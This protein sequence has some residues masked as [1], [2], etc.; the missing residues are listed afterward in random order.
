MFRKVL[1]FLA[2]YQA[3]ALVASL[4]LLTA[5][6]RAASDDRQVNTG[7]VGAA[8]VVLELEGSDE[9]VMG[10]Y[11][12]RKYRL[13]IG[14]GGRWSGDRLILESRSS[15]DR[16]VLRREGAQLAGAL[17][18][19][20]G[21]TLPVRLA[22][23]PLAAGL[24]AEMGDLAPYER[25]QLAELSLVPG[26]IRHDGERTLRDW[27]EPVS[28]ITL[29]RIES[30]YP[31]PVL[32]RINAALARQQWERVSQWFGCEGFD[33]QSGMD[34]SE[35][36]SPY[37]SDDF[38]S[39][40]WFSS[41][42]CA[43]TAHP[44]FGTQGVTFDART[45][46]ELQLE[47]LLYFGKPPAPQPDTSTFFNYRGDIFAPRIVSLLG[48]LYPNEMQPADGEAEEDQCDYADTS[49]W[50]FPS[51]Y[52]TE[53]GLYLGAY[54]ARAQRPCDEP[55][56]SV[57]PW[58]HL[59][60]H[61]G[62]DTRAHRSAVPSATL[63]FGQREFTRDDIANVALDFDHRNFPVLD[64][65]L[66]PEAAKHLE[67]ETIRLL[68]TDVAITVGDKSLSSARVIEPIAEGRIRISGRFSLVEVQGMAG[69]IICAMHLSSE[70]YGSLALLDRLACE[71][72][73]PQGATP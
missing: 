21:R 3:L 18:T 38:V 7:T 49:V 67:A 34:V 54:F 29:F 28:G 40:A 10:R 6:L 53:H 42:S 9:D 68:N 46:R 1:Q 51:W 72:S 24:S 32:A 41:W 63:R 23:A 20:A 71:P 35:A 44:D 31:A 60:W 50:D 65:A 5:P 57:I 14:L 11:F 52:L 4:V 16:L 8:R 66:R 25:H 55:D 47:D 17:T 33:G 19:K 73:D 64:I 61:K 12:Y 58:Q 69:Q 59:T 22:P 70:Q 13:D 45:G 2:R 36:R 15:G 48:Q 39:Y 30:G 26:T 62:D 27:R 37:L 56:W 43:G